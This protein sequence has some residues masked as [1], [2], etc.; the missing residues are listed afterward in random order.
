LVIKGNLGDS[1]SDTR[2]EVRV[3]GDE[4]EEGLG[5]ELE[6]ELELAILVESVGNSPFWIDCICFWFGVVGI[7]ESPVFSST[8]GVGFLGVLGKEYT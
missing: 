1:G 8:M 5:L 3:F 6:L 7:M 2:S 4:D